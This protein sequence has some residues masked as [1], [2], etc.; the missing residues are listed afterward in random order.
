MT[1]P[2]S[3]TQVR[4]LP[5][6]Q[7]SSYLQSNTLTLVN[8]ISV[9]LRGNGSVVSRYTDAWSRLDY[10]LCP[11]YPRNGAAVYFIRSGGEIGKR[12]GML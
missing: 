3:S 11:L 12:S 4:I 5:R 9:K 2:Q 10:G 7:D 1:K 8:L 6:P